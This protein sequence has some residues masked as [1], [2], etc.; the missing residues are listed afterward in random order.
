M[1]Y[2]TRGTDA[3]MA[4]RSGMNFVGREID[5]KLTDK[6]GIPIEPV[7]FMSRT[8]AKTA[9]A[10]AQDRSVTAVRNAKNVRLNKN[11]LADPNPQGGFYV[12]HNLVCAP[13]PP[14]Q[15]LNHAAIVAWGVLRCAIS[16]LAWSAVDTS[17]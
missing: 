16:C 1:I 14:A 7:N 13:N 15:D 9:R 2:G 4:H 11:H 6:M 3:E 17:S 10:A 12:Q 5:R 8:T